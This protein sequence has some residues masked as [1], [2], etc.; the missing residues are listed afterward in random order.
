MSTG[1][2]KTIR[3]DGRTNADG[4]ASRPASIGA[5]G[6]VFAPFWPPGLKQNE[7]Y[8][9]LC[10]DKGRNGTCWLQVYI[11]VDGDAHVMMYD[12]EEPD[13]NVPS[14]LPT[15]RSRTVLG[16]GRNVRTHQALLWLAQAIR[17]DSMDRD[18]RACRLAGESA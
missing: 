17:L 3:A 15:L 12:C 9:V 16:G 1:K 10:D 13:Y 18:A 2:K 4:D 8:Q 7:S 11:A 6:D 5:E 14:T